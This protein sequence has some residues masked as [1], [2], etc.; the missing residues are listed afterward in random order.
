MTARRVSGEGLS[1]SSE[2]VSAT[3][4]GSGT[5]DLARDDE[6]GVSFDY[7]INPNVVTPITVEASSSGLLDGWIDYNQDGDWDDFGEKIFDS[8]VLTGGT[9]SLEFTAPGFALVGETFARF[10]FS[11]GGRTF[12]TGVIV[13]GEVEDYLVSITP[14]TPPI[15]VNDTYLTDEDTQLNEATIGPLGKGIL[16]NDQDTENQDLVVSEV[17]GLAANVTM[18]VTLEHGGTVTVSLIIGSSRIGLAWETPL[19]N[20]WLL[21][22]SKDMPEESTSWKLPSYSTAFRSTMG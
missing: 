1:P 14:G 15:V 10:R 12:P 21:A 13:N 11:V 5:V 9:N 6:D 8:V 19:R 22:I 7:V 20:A 18:P 3:D 16:A 2:G 17:N 4:S